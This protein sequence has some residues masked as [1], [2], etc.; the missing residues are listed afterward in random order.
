MLERYGAN[1]A[2]PTADDAGATSALGFWSYLGFYPVTPGVAQYVIGSPTFDRADLYL[3]N[4]KVFSVTARNNSPQ[5][6][7][8]QSATLNGKPWN[9]TYINHEDVVA[10]GQ[11]V[12][13]MGPEPNRHWGTAPDSRPYS[14]SDPAPGT[15]AAGG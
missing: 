8:I 10:G 9:K 7:Y 4:G 6:V 13:E 1:E 11:I 3:P 5:N 2:L 12:F 14:L 15:R